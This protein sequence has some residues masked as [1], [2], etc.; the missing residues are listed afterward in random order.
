MRSNPF[1]Y[2]GETES[3]RLKFIFVWNLIVWS[4]HHAC[5]QVAQVLLTLPCSFSQLGMLSG[6][7]LQ[8]L[9]VEHR[10]ARRRRTSASRITSSR[11]VSSSPRPVLLLLSI[12][13]LPLNFSVPRPT[14]DPLESGIFGHQI[15]INAHTPP[16]DTTKFEY[17][18]DGNILLSFFFP[19]SA[20]SGSRCWMGCWGLTGKPLVWPSTVPSFFSAPLSS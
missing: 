4:C 7:L 16:L 11:S 2:S 18:I 10:T 13:G 19:L 8:L 1:L 20:S 12:S 14:Q 5:A 15:Y 17:Q 6:V 9:Y 3:G